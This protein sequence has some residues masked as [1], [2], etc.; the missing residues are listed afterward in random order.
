[1]TYTSKTAKII[2]TWY[3]PKRFS[4]NKYIAVFT[5]SWRPSRHRWICSS[6]CWDVANNNVFCKCICIPVC[7]DSYSLSHFLAKY[8][9]LLNPATHVSANFAA[10]DH[11]AITKR[12][13]PLPPPSRTPSLTTATHFTTTYLILNKTVFNTSK[14]LS[15]LPSSGP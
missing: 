5:V 15:H 6:R 13:V 4:K 11:I 12:P 2:K 7:I 3:Y 14:I 9:L 1:M 10:S 8:Q